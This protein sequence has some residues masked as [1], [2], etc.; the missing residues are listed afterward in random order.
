MLSIRGIKLDR[1][2]GEVRDWRER[3]D[4]GYSGKNMVLENYRELLEQF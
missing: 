1:E 3:E 2:M 4:R